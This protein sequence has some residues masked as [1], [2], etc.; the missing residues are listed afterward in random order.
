MYHN[1]ATVSR[2][3]STLLLPVS[4]S[5]HFFHIVRN[6]AYTSHDRSLSSS[7]KGGT[8]KRGEKAKVTREH[9]GQ[10]GA[11]TSAA[12]K[13]RPVDLR[14]EELTIAAHSCPKH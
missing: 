1:H 7:L 8:V 9:S 11:S 2:R 3:C 4:S 13:S 10:S 5:H 6:D 12:P 14:K